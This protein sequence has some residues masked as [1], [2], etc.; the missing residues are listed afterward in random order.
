LSALDAVAGTAVDGQSVKIG[1]GA[2]TAA[3]AGVAALD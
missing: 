1:A 2:G 3:A